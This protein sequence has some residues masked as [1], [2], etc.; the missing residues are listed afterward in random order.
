MAY[1]IV[2]IGA[3]LVDTEIS[4]TDSDLKELKI[5]KG[6]MTLCDEKQQSHYIHTVQVGAQV[7]IP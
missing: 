3:A 5:E 7:P 2:G 6:L 4:V 1:Q